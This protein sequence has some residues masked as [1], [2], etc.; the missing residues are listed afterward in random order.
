VR[1]RGYAACRSQRACRHAL[2]LAGKPQ[3]VAALHQ[4][5]LRRPRH[6][7]RRGR[8][9]GRRRNC[10]DQ[11]PLRHRRAGGGDEPVGQPRGGGQA[12]D[13]AECQRA[14]GHDHPRLPSARH[15][16]RRRRYSVRLSRPWYQSVRLHFNERGHSD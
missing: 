14:G 7:R 4:L 8:G 9:A 2:S 1:Y 15:H 12:A 13:A 16:R 11:R 3:P 10:G 6:P 5:D